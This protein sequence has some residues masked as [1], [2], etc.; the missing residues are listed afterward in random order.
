MENS[1]E[2]TTNNVNAAVHMALIYDTFG[3]TQLIKDPTRETLDTTTLFDQVA[4]THPEKTPESRVLKV[5]RSD[6]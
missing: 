6:C 3:L 2:N 1:P 5:A 4:L